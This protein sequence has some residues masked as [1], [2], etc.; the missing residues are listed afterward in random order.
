VLLK[1]LN[2]PDV[3]LHSFN[4]YRDDE[5]L[6]ARYFGWLEDLNITNLISSEELIIPK[7]YRFVKNS[8]KRFT[9]KNSIGFFIKHN[10]T[11][12]VIGTVKLDQISFFKRIAWD[13]IMI[14]E[15]DYFGM[16]IGFKTYKI[17]LAYGFSILGLRKIS[18]GCNE[19]NFAMIRIFYKIGYCEE[20]RLRKADYINGQYSDHLLY[21]IFD[22]EFAEKND[23]NLGIQKIK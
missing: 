5:I 22:Y 16:G 4:L 18:G 12:R 1:N 19:H 15:K 8:F 20:G 11:N 21:G 7:S 2:E 23:V 10:P 13:G 14:G 3:E 17:L 9:G 6:A